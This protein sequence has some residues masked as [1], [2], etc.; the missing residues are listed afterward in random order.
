[1]AAYNR[2]AH[3]GSLTHLEFPKP[4]TKF[5]IFEVKD[6]VDLPIEQEIMT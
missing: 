2:K 5:Y 4:D 1:M 3:N 6:D